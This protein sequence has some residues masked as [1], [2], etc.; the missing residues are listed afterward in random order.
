M[1]IGYRHAVLGLILG[2]LGSARAQNQTLVFDF[3]KNV[4][5]WEGG[6]SDYSNESGFN[7]E[8]ARSFLPKPLDTAEYGL[9]LE[10][11]N[12]SDDLFMFLRRKVEGLAPSSKYEVR[13]KVRL[14][15]KYASDAAGIG[16]APGTSV[17]L[18]IGAVPFKPVDQNGR[19]NVEKGNQSQPGTQ[20]DTIGNIAVGPGINHYVSIE[21]SNARVFT[22]TT[23][24]DGSAWII[25]G[26]DSGFEGLTELYY[27]KV[28]AAFTK[29]G[30]TGLARA[31]AGRPAGS[32]K[33]D[34]VRADGRTLTRSSNG[35]YPAF[36]LE[37]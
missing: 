13:F 15:S 28:E 7:F 2:A 16:G 30:G 14:A 12:R 27:Q 9:K 24:A 1:R 17:V 3:N 23:A 29:Q 22:F 4:D 6:Y 26:T 19:M 11:M 21:R 37:P 25:L 32:L 34:A 35:A 5:G 36:G 8:F 31:N 18:K 33:T 10:G 20:M